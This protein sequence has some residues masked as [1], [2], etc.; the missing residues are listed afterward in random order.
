MAKVC[1]YGLVVIMACALL[2]GCGGSS[3]DN[4]RRDLAATQAELGD[5][6]AEL[7]A[8]QTEQE[9]QEDT[10]ALETR[11]AKLTAAITALAAAQAADDVEAEEE[12][13]PTPA[14]PAPGPNPNTCPPA[15]HAKRRGQP[16]RR[17]PARGLWAYAGHA[18]AY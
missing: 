4:A 3:D 5:V 9:E 6:Q 1:G 12:T 13:T 11:I 2:V 18:Y 15:K 16:A 7:E 8:V 14:T 17:A 10:E